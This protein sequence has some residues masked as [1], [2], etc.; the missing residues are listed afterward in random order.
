RLQRLQRCLQSGCVS[1]RSV[2]GFAAPGRGIYQNSLP[3]GF[4]SFLPENLSRSASCIRSEHAICT[5][6]PFLD[7]GAL[8]DVLQLVGPQIH[9]IRHELVLREKVVSRHEVAHDVSRSICS[10]FHVVPHFLHRRTVPHIDVGLIGALSELRRKGRVV[11]EELAGLEFLKVLSGLVLDEA[12]SRVVPELNMKWRVP[13]PG[14]KHPYMPV[15][16]VIRV[17]DHP[18]KQSLGIAQCT[19]ARK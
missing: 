19:I 1:I 4:N 2:E 17:I 3:S 15:L 13:R 16:T 10:S 18:A 8:I 7:N 11:E 6:I 9:L 12:H 14:R 5:W